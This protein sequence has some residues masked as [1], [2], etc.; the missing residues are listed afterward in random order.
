[1]LDRYNHRALSIRNPRFRVEVLKF[2][3]DFELI[4]VARERNLTAKVFMWYRS[5]F[6]NVIIPVDKL[7]NDLGLYIKDSKEALVDFEI[8]W[9]KDIYAIFRAKKK[10]IVTSQVTWLRE[11]P[12]S[13]ELNR[14]GC[15]MEWYKL[16]YRISR[17]SHLQAFQFNIFHRT[18]PCMRYLHKLTIKL[19]DAC[20]FCGDG[21]D[22]C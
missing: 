1:M 12:D 6:F 5:H 16:P 19:S 13:E 18:I 14:Q 15:W 11:F 4:D 7:M 10:H 8:L 20:V 21:D 2:L 3:S 22:F 9:A 17:E